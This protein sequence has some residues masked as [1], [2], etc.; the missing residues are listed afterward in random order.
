M[1]RLSLCVLISGLL[2]ISSLAA[3]VP[4]QTFTVKDYLQHQWTD[5]I[6]HFPISYAGKSAPKTLALTDAEGKPVP[7]QITGLAHKGGRVTGTAWTVVTVPP[8]GEV[9]LHLQPGTPAQS[10]L[11]LMQQGKE[12]LLGNDK[13]VLRLP[14]FTGTPALPMDLTALPAPLLSMAVVGKGAWLG[15]G[16]WVN[17]DKPLQV[18]DAKT[19]I[20]EEGPVRIT[21]RYR[22]TFTDDHYYQADI[23]LGARQDAALFTD[24]TD[25][26]AP[27]AIFRF[28]FQPGLNANQLFWQ[29]NYYADSYKGITGTPLSFEGEKT[30]CHLCPWA[31]WW[32]RDRTTWAGLYRNDTEPFLGMIAIR[33]SRWTPIG[34]D[35][36]DRT[37]IPITSRPNGQ[38][39]ISLGLLAWTKK[40]QDGTTEFSKA[41]REL[42]FTV[43]NTA[44]FLNREKMAILKE[45]EEA[46]LKGDNRKWNSLLEQGW[47]LFKLRAQLSKYSE[48]P[49]DEVKDFG[50]DFKSAVRDKKRPYLLFT[51]EDIERARKQVKTVPGLKTELANATEYLTRLNPDGLIAKINKEPDGWKAYFRENY[52]GNGMYENSPTS[53][54]GSDDPRYGKLLAAGVKGLATQVVDQFLN[55]PTRMSLG[56]NGHMSGTTLLRLLLAYDAIADSTYLTPEDKAS[57]DAALVFGGYVF[58]HP[59]YW[60]TDVGLCSAN[61]NMTSLLKLPLGLVGLYLDGHP[62]AEH[63]L[64]FAE[65]ELQTEIKDWISP[66]GAWLEC[67]MYQSPSLDG[68]FMLAQALKNIKGKDYFSEPNF[69]A[70]MDYYGFIL[71]PP[72]VRYPTKDYPV[73][74]TIPS[75]GDAFPYFTTPYNGWM[76]RV[77]AKSDPAYSARQQFYWQ[78]QSFSAINGGRANAFMAAICDT[79]LPA[80]PPVELSKAFEGFGNVLRTS[81]TDA[82][83]SYISHRCG[84]YT[85]HYDP[86]DP[87]S[88][89]YYAKGAPLCIDFG[90]RSASSEEV[91][92]MWRPDYHTA[93]SFD[94]PAATPNYWGASVGTVEASKQGQEVRSLPGVI[95]YS[96]GA[97]FGSGNQRNNRH[98]LLI[99]SEDPLGATY[100]V[101]RD[102]TQDGQPNQ[103]FTWNIWCPAKEPEIAGNVAHF[104][105]QFGVDL[106]AHVLTPA[107]PQFT[108]DKY[109]YEQ[110]VWPWWGMGKLREDQT[111]VHVKKAG[112]K[113]DFFSVLY[114]RAAGQGPA[115]V[116]A[117][118]DGRGVEVKHLEGTDV[119]LLSPGKPAK[120]TAGDVEVS[121]EIA[122]AR[123]YTI[124]VLS[125][126][127]LKGAGAVATQGAWGVRSD[128]PVALTVLGARVEGESSG[129]AHTAQIALPASFGTAKVTLDG[130]AI[131]VKQEKNLLTIDLPAGNHTFKITM[132]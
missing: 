50:F 69:K 70:T 92:T 73:P 79:E 112:S 104:P 35:G 28:S 126:A 85:A 36:F 53:Y 33:P 29:N 87:N 40:K 119:V 107:N 45:G 90:H 120:I 95:D 91:Y 102:I 83:A 26:E 14:R 25:V 99:K 98:L 89:I 118:G 7:C 72:D 123:K 3:P 30:I 66:G 86:G 31:F 9:T 132:K 75:I 2:A 20:V 124:G 59:D 105:G 62:R 117:L 110:W 78:R 10:A 122:F 60:N 74:M 71:T 19:S 4:L 111:G 121:G 82:K 106:D 41:H 64:K 57:I 54:V 130:K 131:T 22:L 17:A 61:P 11:R 47:Y 49:L 56:S 15:Q 80:A 6:V 96:T 13:I 37:L 58:D 21:V 103:V 100:V 115:Q 46:R 109:G 129:V 1:I 5:E 94:R 81:W 55:N 116:T 108:K 34:W 48:F 18:K 38:V 114:P 93:V 43:G 101:M 12:Y 42:A 16:S 84:Y 97:S 44:D 113:E 125:L 88:I 76:A 127:V 27:K 65:T 52:V 128:G 68:M 8:K 51:Q 24:E 39:D 32:Q 63:W 67:P 77:T 23:T